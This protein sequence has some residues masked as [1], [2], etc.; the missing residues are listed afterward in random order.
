VGATREILAAD[1]LIATE[2]FEFI[3]PK[4]VLPS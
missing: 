3:C 1:G 4:G 2:I